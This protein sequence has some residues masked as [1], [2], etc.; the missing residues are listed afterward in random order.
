MTRARNTRTYREALAALR[1]PHGLPACCCT[2]KTRKHTQPP[3]TMPENMDQGHAARSAAA[4]LA[5]SAADSSSGL[6]PALALLC[7]AA[8]A[9]LR[10][11]RVPRFSMMVSTCRRVVAGRP[12]LAGQCP[13]G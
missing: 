3:S 7:A 13:A 2:H 8:D 6:G 10:V 4:A 1:M 12:A 9:A 11:W 5:A